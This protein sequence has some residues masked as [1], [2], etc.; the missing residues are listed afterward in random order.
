MKIYKIS[1]KILLNFFHLVTFKL[2]LD[3]IQTSPY[4]NLTY[5]GSRAGSG[6]VIFENGFSDQD[7]VP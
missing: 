7:P 4:F 2:V 5:R 1:L 3:H 6:S